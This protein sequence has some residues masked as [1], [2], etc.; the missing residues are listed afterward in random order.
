MQ[1]KVL[2]RFSTPIYPGNIVYTN[3]VKK[4][5]CPNNC[6]FCSRPRSGKTTNKPNIYETKAGVS[7]YLARSPSAET[8]LK[9]LQS[10]IK[11]GDREIAFVGLGEPLTQFSKLLKILRGIKKRYAISTRLD[12]NGVLRGHHP[13]AARQLKH[14]GL[15]EIRISLNAINA[16]EYQT[17]CRPSVKNAFFHLTQF[18]KECTK[19]GINTKVSF[20]TGFNAPGIKNHP[21]TEL[22]NFAHTLGIK[23]EDVIFRDYVPPI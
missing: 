13:E 19:E 20:V 18:I 8:V 14:A 11:K 17:L 12:T 10:T 3:L 15:D 22:L 21:K 1:G 9:Q 2:Y 7:L 5:A 23:K 6:R 16:T 4:Y